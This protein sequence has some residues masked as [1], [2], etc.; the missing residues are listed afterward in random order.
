MG[1]RCGTFG[2]AKIL[3][4]TM[5]ALGCPM[6]RADRPLST[7]ELPVSTRPHFCPSRPECKL[8]KAAIHPFELEAAQRPIP[9]LQATV[10][11]SRKLTVCYPGRKGLKWGGKETVRI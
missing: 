10:A 1:E 8:L 6:V 4:H 7:P 2:L 5:S 9:A 3:A 11:A